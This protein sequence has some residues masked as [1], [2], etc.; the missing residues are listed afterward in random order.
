LLM[1]RPR[2][3]S[4]IACKMWTL[5]EVQQCDGVMHPRILIAI[6]GFVYDVTDKGSIHYGPG[7]RE[8]WCLGGTYHVLAGEDASLALA[9]LTLPRSK[10]ELRSAGYDISM[11]SEKEQDVLEGWCCKFESKY[12]LVGRLDGWMK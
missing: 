8:W 11:L 5:E 3:T 7:K 10:T 9:T 4:P 6:N 2:W 12:V 1:G